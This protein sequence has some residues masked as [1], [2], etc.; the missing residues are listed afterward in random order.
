MRLSDLHRYLNTK[1]VNQTSGEP[2]GSHNLI[3]NGRTYGVSD[4]VRKRLNISLSQ[5]IK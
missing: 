4:E 2:S 5:I 1:M 3:S